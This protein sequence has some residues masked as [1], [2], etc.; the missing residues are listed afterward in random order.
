M[1]GLKTAAAPDAAPTTTRPKDRIASLPEAAQRRLGWLAQRADELADLSEGAHHAT[2]KAEARYL[3]ARALVE[4]LKEAAAEE[5]ATRKEV[6]AA[7]K[8]SLAS[9]EEALPRAR[10]SHERAMQAQSEIIRQLHATRD[11]QAEAKRFVNGH[12]AGTLVD[13]RPELKLPATGGC[14]ALVAKYR[15]DALRLREDKKE[16][17]HAPLSAEEVKAKVRSEVEALAR[18]G[19]PTVSG[20]GEPFIDHGEGHIHP[21][22]VGIS[23]PKK[24]LNGITDITPSVVDAA[25]LTAWLFKEKLIETLEANIDEAYDTTDGIDALERRKLVRALDRQI[26]DVERLEAEAVWQAIDSGEDVTWRALPADAVL[27]LR[28]DV[29]LLREARA[30][31]TEV[32]G[33]GGR[34]MIT[35][36]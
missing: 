10:R 30:Q 33:G 2:T 16:A 22:S 27:G 34:Q 36:H 12:P 6:S 11:L 23:W 15:S 4:S 24:R 5:R 20:A 31:E 1:F 13:A 32:S 8:A 28:V 17:Q 19:A 26:A 21:P 3:D 29:A 7:T 14:A 25:A 18:R 35:G 9:A